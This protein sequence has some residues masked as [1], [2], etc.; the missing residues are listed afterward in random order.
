[1]AAAYGRA[2]DEPIVRNDEVSATGR[3]SRAGGAV[4]PPWTCHDRL[5]AD[6]RVTVTRRN[7]PQRR[8]TGGLILPPVV[9]AGHCAVP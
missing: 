1:M 4:P 9:P 5:A 7:S 6:R 8:E 3:P 2:P